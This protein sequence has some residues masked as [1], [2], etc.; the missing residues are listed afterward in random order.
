MSGVNPQGCEVHSFKAPTSVDLDHD[1][2]WRSTKVLPERGRIGIFNRSY[3]EEVLVVRVHPEIL[4]RQKLPKPLV[5]RRIWE[6]RFED[7][8]NFESYLARNGVLILKFFLNVSKKEQKKRFLERLEKPDKNWKFSL[9]DLNERA[10][11]SKYQRAYEEAIRH[12]ASE[13]APWF[14]V[15]ADT[16]WFTK[17]VVAAALVDGMASLGL[18]FPKPAPRE[19]KDLKVAKAR[20]LAE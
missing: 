2:M 18:E 15:P 4:A 9:A 5:T 6:Q 12:T 13:H 8:K 20:L 7:I 17:V 10:Y 3:Y 1:Y 19:L 16:K 14:I 11:W